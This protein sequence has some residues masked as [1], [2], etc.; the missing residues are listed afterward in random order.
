MLQEDTIVVMGDNLPQRTCTLRGV[1]K[2]TTTNGTAAAQLDSNL[3]DPA[4]KVPL[5]F[6]L[7]AMVF[8]GG[9]ASESD[10]DGPIT[11]SVAVRIEPHG[12]LEL[13]FPE[14]ANVRVQLDGITYH[15]YMEFN[16]PPR[17]GR[18]QY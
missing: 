6:P 13:I 17:A 18:V 9:V 16:T 12:R 4:L 3:R 5:C 15:P 11:R 7:R 10:P 14:E 1:V 2:F 8:F